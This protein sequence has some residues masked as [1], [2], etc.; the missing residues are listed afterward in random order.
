MWEVRGR[1][2]DYR[3]TEKVPYF[4]CVL[5][6]FLL[7]PREA[8]SKTRAKQGTAKWDKPPCLGINHGRSHP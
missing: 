3:G 6:K 2:G 4:S 5:I 8:D 7:I 1:L